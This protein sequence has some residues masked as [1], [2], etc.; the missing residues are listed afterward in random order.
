MTR[1]LIADDHEIL[2]RGLRQILAD[3]FKSLKV[4]EATD[5]KT[6]LEAARQQPWDIILLDINMPGRSGLEVLEDLMRLYPKLPVLM[7]SGFPEEDY[8]LRS[9]KLGASGYLTKQSAADE[10]I[11]AVRKALAG[12]K[13]VTAALAE[14]LASSLA[15]DAPAAPHETLSNRELQVLRLIAAGKS[16]KEIGA[17]LSLSEKTVGTYRA[18]LA[19]KMGL[20]TNVDLTRYALQHHL[21]D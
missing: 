5:A 17:E 6:V 18:R 9:F 21:V 11:V 2:R 16:I 12:G 8:A 7:L 10:L 15:G 3:E 1:V 20:G 14:K 13:Y 4:G 19:E